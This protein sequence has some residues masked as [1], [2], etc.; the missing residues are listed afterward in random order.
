MKNM[1]DHTAACVITVR[2]FSRNLTA[3]MKRRIP[4]SAYVAVFIGNTPYDGLSSVAND[5]G[6]DGT[7][8]WSGAGLNTRKITIDLT[9]KLSG[10][11]RVS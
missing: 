7:V 4:D 8:R 5:P 9:R 1:T 2:A 10:R 11:Y 6:T 3:L